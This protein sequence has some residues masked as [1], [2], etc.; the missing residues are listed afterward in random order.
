M[1]NPSIIL[2]AL[3]H[4][5]VN[6]LHKLYLLKS[7]LAVSDHYILIQTLSQM[8][9]QDISKNVEQYYSENLKTK[10]DVKTTVAY[11]ENRQKKIEELTK[12]IHPAVKQK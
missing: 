9:N 4:F 5:R 6:A 7:I 12:T 11:S 10:N 1:I 3:C 8:A 2:K